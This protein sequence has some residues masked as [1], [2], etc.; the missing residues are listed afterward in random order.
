MPY[1][2]GSLFAGIGG[3]DL[4]FQRAGFKVVWQVEKDEWARKVLAKNFPEAERYE[5]ITDR[6]LWDD[7]G[8]RPINHDLQRVDVMCGGFPCQDISNA[9]LRAGIEGARSGLVTH[10]VRLIAEL[11]PRV[12]LM[13]NVA[14]L[15]GRGLGTVLGLLHEIGYDAEWE[16]VSAADVGAPHLRERIWI[17]AY[18]ARKLL[19]GSGIFA[20]KAGRSELADC[21]RVI[22]D[23]DIQQHEGGASADE[24]SAATQLSANAHGDDV[25]GLFAGGPNPEERCIAGARPAGPRDAGVA[26]QWA[27]EPNV[28]RVADGVPGRV[29]RLRGLG[30]A[31]V[32]QIPEMYARRIAELLAADE[33]SKVEM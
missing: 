16:I 19:D 15:L 26:G 10:M 14:A 5:D 20:G 21:G 32:P 4:A 1:A 2:I 23:A 17:L 7:E 27:V 6:F 28:G 24:W 31:V 22:S 9:G 30:N 18:P 13:E 11:R 8:F 3:F 29:D 25:Q 33:C 12:V